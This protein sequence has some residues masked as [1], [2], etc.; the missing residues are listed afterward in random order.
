MCRNAAVAPKLSCI[1]TILAYRA[2]LSDTNE[3]RWQNQCKCA[4]AVFAAA[5]RVELPVLALRGQ[6]PLCSLKRSNRRLAPV[7]AAAAVLHVI[8]PCTFVFVLNLRPSSFDQT[9]SSK[10]TMIVTLLLRAL[11]IRRRV[12]QLMA[13]GQRQLYVGCAGS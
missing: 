13:A 8:M 10:G 2:R 11:V 6:E 3:A 4:C 1:A 9:D 12:V 7:A 5:R